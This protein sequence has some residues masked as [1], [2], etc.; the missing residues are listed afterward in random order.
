MKQQNTLIKNN[1]I[2]IMPDRTESMKIKR[3]KDSNRFSKP[4]FQYIWEEDVYICPQNNKLEYQN[5]RKLN[6]KLNRVY[7]TT[8]CK[9]CKYNQECCKGRKKEIF[10]S[11]HPI[12]NKNER[13][14]QFRSRK[15][16]LQKKIPH[17]RNLL[18]NH[19]RITQ[20]PRNTKKNN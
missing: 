3:K 13:R 20:I 15:R 5:N 14:L 12:K 19:Q 8:K 2:T 7:S 11:A 6:N 1:I 9:N 17:R 10:H 18:R 4:H 16:N